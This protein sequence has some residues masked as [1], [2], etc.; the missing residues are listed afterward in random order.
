LFVRVTH[1]DGAAITPFTFTANMAFSPSAGAYNLAANR[2]LGVIWQGQAELD[3]TA[4]L[5]QAGIHGKATKVDLSIDNSLFAM[6]ETSSV[7]YI[8]KKQLEGVTITAVV[9]EPSSFALLGFGAL[10]LMAYSRRQR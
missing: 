6:S 10:S 8:K 9:P 3:I 2:G 5:A 7:A 1:V 4:A